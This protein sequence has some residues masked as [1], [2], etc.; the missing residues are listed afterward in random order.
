[1]KVTTKFYKLVVDNVPVYVGYTNR[2]LND[3]LVE[4]L[5][6][7]DIPKTTEIILLEEI[8]IN[9][10]LNLE[11]VYSKADYISNK[12]ADWVSKVGTQAS[13]YQ[14]ALGGGSTV[15]GSLKHFVRM[16]SND[17]MTMLSDNVI[18]GL[19]SEFIKL[20][21]RA[22]EFISDT[23]PVEQIR[24]ENFIRH[25]RDVEQSKMYD[26]INSTRDS[27]YT[28]VNSFINRTK[29]HSYPT[30]IK[31]TKDDEA[32]YAKNLIRTATELGMSRA[33]NF[34][35]S[36]KEKERSRVMSFI[37]HTNDNT[38]GGLI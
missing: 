32:R 2:G 20:R 30:L 13:K 17:E 35:G 19:Y 23:R 33:T 28:R 22:K 27:E 29:E 8:T 26:F 4:H 6:F 15:W 36:T 10:K 24:L 7:K 34:I 9:V 38:R 18:E 3:R 25:T 5:F 21:D 11:D 16:F 37:S 12:E 31:G 1:M 14:K